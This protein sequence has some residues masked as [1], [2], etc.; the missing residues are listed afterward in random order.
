MRVKCLA[1]EH[2]TMTPTRA[3]TR[4]ARSGVERTNH[5][6]TAPPTICY[7]LHDSQ[8]LHPPLLFLVPPPALPPRYASGR[9]DT[10]L[11]FTDTRKGLCFAVVT[12]NMCE[13]VTKEMMQVRKKECCCTAGKAWGTDCQLCPRR[14]T[15]NDRSSPPFYSF[16]VIFQFGIFLLDL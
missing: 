4:T 8:L 2:N 5:E 6:A 10:K 3:R 16:L 14:G 1:Q 7:L 9:L 12:D 15:G 13:A 11:Y